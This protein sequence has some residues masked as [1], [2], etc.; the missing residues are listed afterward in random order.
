MLKELSNTEP[1]GNSYYSINSDYLRNITL[2][3]LNQYQH[4]KMD[5][6]KG[7]SMY[8]VNS[9]DFLFRYLQLQGK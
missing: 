6:F 3:N 1:S 2:E 4:G 8:K 9:R 5:T 7:N